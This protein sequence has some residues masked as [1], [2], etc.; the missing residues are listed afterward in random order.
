MIGFAYFAGA[1]EEGPIWAFP[2][3]CWIFGYEGDGSN[4]YPYAYF[5]ISSSIFC[6]HGTSLLTTLI[7]AIFTFA[8]IFYFKQVHKIISINASRIPKIHQYQLVK[9]QFLCYLIMKNSMGKLNLS[10]RLWKK[11]FNSFINNR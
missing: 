8:S 10:N 9:I 3:G 7:S 4:F 11:I 6:G 2:W 5:F 1:T